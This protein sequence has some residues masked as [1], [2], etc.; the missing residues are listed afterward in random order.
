M[1]W[2]TSA[3]L[4]RESS[5]RIMHATFAAVGVENDLR[6]VAHRVTLNDL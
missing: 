1:A 6:L 2:I 5:R 4:T 3:S